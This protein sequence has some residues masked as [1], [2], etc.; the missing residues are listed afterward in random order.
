M[1][2][3]IGGWV[4][5]CMWTIGCVFAKCRLM[6]VPNFAFVVKLHRICAKNFSALYR[7]TSCH[8]ESVEPHP[9]LVSVFDVDKETYITLLPLD[10]INKCGMFDVT[11]ALKF[12]WSNCIIFAFLVIETCQ[13]SAA[14]LWMSLAGDGVRL[15]CCDGDVVPGEFPQEL[16]E[17]DWRLL[18]QFHHRWCRLWQ[19]CT[20]RRVLELCHVQ[21]LS[22]KSF[23]VHFTVW[24]RVTLQLERLTIHWY[25]VCSCVRRW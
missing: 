23:F 19:S 4:W 1:L 10:I 14:V 7:T 20:T 13:F 21:G 9:H 17:T 16:Q 18:L 12:V 3:S 6:N 5:G 2:Y 15:W 25:I 8:C 24:H 22:G 11:S